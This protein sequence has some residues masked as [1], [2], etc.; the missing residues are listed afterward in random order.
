MKRFALF[1]TVALTLP[2]HA[3]SI[4]WL[5]VTVP[6]CK[7]RHMIQCTQIGTGKVQLLATDFDTYNRKIYLV[8][9]DGAEGYISGY[10]VDDKHFLTDEDPAIIAKRAKE[11]AVAAKKECDRRGGVSIGMTADQ[12]RSSCWGKPQRINQTITAR[13]KHEQWVYGGS[14]VYLENGTVTSIQTSR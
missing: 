8:N 3:Q 6:F 12:V 11:K 7:D 2:A 9:H 10:I 5:N 4:K 14:Y 13:G 1:A